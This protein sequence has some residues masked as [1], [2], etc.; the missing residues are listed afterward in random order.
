[1]VYVLSHTGAAL[2]PTERH[3]KVRRLLRDGLAHVVTLTPFTI[4]L[5][6]ESTEFTQPVTLGVDAGTTHVGMSA[7]TDSREIFSAEVT[8]RT[9]IVKLLSQR[10]ETRRTRRSRLRYRAPR[11][12][13]RRRPE[14]WL[15]PSAENRVQTH[16]KLIKRVRSILPVTR[17]VIEVAQFDAQLLKNP[18]IAG[19]QYQQGERMGFW[20]TREY[21][22]CRDGHKCQHCKGKTKDPVLN[23]HHIESR[24]TGGDAPNNLITLCE[25]CHKAYHKGEIEL[26]VKRGT[27]LRDAALMNVMRWEL[28]RR[29]RSLWQN[30]SL[31][32]GYITKHTRISTGLEKSHRIDARCVSGHPMAE[33]SERWFCMKQTR[34]HNRQ[35]MKARILKGGR[36]KRNQAPYLVRGFRL[37]DKV[38]LNGTEC[39]IFGRRSSGSFDVRL[40]DG[41][42]VH[43]GIGHRKLRFLE[44]SR[45]FL[46][47]LER[48][49]AIPLPTEA[50]SI[51]A[52][53]S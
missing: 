43:A 50:G 21:V 35:V 26:N 9:D 27:S 16:L 44:A 53:F 45:R 24:Q 12:D 52:H 39:F 46:I 40:I 7:T 48:N 5:D 36:L 42:K 11:F 19:M 17:T 25:T 10:R 47:T 49:G 31:T 20:N 37:F 13:N 38:M 14:G 34:R 22:L 51:L 6:Y 28:Y 23:V 30:V 3:G 18:D 29:A 4:R 41:T 1:M 8:L 2:M 15:A 32:Y 33:P